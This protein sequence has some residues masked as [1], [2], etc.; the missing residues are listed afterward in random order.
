MA[1]FGHRKMGRAEYRNRV[2]EL[3]IRMA[4][5]AYSR[6]YLAEHLGL[7][8]KTN[9]RYLDDYEVGW[10]PFA[11]NSTRYW[12]EIELQDDGLFH[13][14]EVDPSY[15]ALLGFDPAA[16]IGMT[17]PAA[18]GHE[19]V[20]ELVQAAQQVLAGQP[21]PAML[22]QWAV[23]QGTGRELWFA[24]SLV[25]VSERRIRIRLAP[26]ADEAVKEVIALRS[27]FALDSQPYA[28][29]DFA[30]VILDTERRV[31]DQTDE[32]EH[33][34]GYSR[35][36]LVGKPLA[37][38]QHREAADP[39]HPIV[40]RLFVPVAEGFFGPRGTVY[41]TWLYH[42]Q[43]GERVEVAAH[44][45]PYGDGCLRVSFRRLASAPAPVDDSDLQRDVPAPRTAPT[46][47]LDV[48]LGDDG[49]TRLQ[50]ADEAFAWW[51]GLDSAEVLRGQTQEEITGHAPF[52]ELVE[53]FHQVLNP[54]AARPE[55]SQLQWIRHRQSGEQLWFSASGTRIDERRV[56][57]LLTPIAAPGSTAEPG[58][59]GDMEVHLRL[60]SDG[61]WGAV[62]VDD[63]FA[64]FIGEAR[65]EDL[66]GQSGVELTGH[67][68]VTPEAEA[69]LMELLV[70]RG[71]ELQATS[72]VLHR[73]T[74]TRRWVSVRGSRLAPD[75]LRYRLSALPPGTDTVESSVI[76]LDVD[77]ARLQEQ[78][79]D[80][81]HLVDAIRRP[82]EH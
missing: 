30:E 35:A 58:D 38:I 26:L 12:L 24:T 11:G 13:V 8:P 72:W 1:S 77:V 65:G 57:V 32:F 31:L 51:I 80:L 44:L 34:F 28:Y 21:C 7:D 82:S 55:H 41:A 20:P 54:S 39:H 3:D 18:T 23:Q 76:G 10:P 36:S 25:R 64:H 49:V 48:E 60:Y 37:V 74:Q 22:L 19:S 68:R 5:K 46:F 63:S 50:R 47:A 61:R 42:G 69:A 4:G 73:P 43:T 81:E 17:S 59:D 16:M 67:P 78:L 71:Q 53:R 70:E 15:A 56:R 75:T 62:H 29:R 40:Q 52:P 9:R 6:A 2:R 79:N 66:L 14:S 45:A 27:R 33:C